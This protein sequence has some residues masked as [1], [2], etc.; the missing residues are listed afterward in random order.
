MGNSR[1]LGLK[2]EWRTTPKAV[3]DPAWVF[4]AADYNGD[5]W[6]DS[7]VANVDREMYSL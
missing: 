3:L 5:G 2:R 1:T 4:D 6:M 7:F